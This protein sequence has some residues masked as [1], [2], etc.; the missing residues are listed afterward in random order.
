MNMENLLL[1]TKLCLIRYSKII[2]GFLS[3]AAGVC[4]RRGLLSGV[5]AMERGMAHYSHHFVR[6]AR[7][8]AQGERVPA[9]PGQGSRAF[10]R[11][12]CRAC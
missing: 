3:I 12:G 6:D 5:H 7:P 11:E 2:R 4:S 10:F 1:N 9:Q 8:M